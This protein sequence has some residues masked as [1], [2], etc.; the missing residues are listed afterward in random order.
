MSDPYSTDDD[1]TNVLGNI[2][3]RLPEWV[4][5]ADWRTLAHAEAVDM[6]AKV[7]PRGIPAFAGDGLVVV[8]YAEA[9]LAAAAILEAIRVNLPD[10]GDA[11]DQLREDAVRILSDGVIGYPAD[12]ELVDDDDNPETPSVPVQQAPVMS[13]FTP[14]SAFPDPYE[15]G[16][17]D[18]E[19]FQ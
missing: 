15:V 12:S 9:K 4:T 1:V 18:G 19:R 7:Y 3:N 17:V 2:G 14:L 11:P 13:S 8:R 10:L 16:R 5:V 6:L